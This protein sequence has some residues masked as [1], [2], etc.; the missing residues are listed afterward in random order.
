MYPR[1]INVFTKCITFLFYL[2]CFYVHLLQ[3]HCHFRYFRFQP[4]CSKGFRF[5]RML[6][7]VTTF[8]KLIALQILL[9]HSN[10]TAKNRNDITSSAPKLKTFRLINQ[11]KLKLFKRFYPYR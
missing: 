2:I 11:S 9:Q 7:L 6:H 3:I 10:W 5:P 1:E 4:P 8:G